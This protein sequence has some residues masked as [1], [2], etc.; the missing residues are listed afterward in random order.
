MLDCYQQLVYNL[1]MLCGT[2]NLDYFLKEINM[3]FKSDSKSFKLFQALRNG[4]SLTE[5]QITQRFGLK[6]PTATIS[7]L[8]LNHGVCVYADE[9]FDSHNRRTVKYAIGKPS[10]KLIAAGYKAM[11]LGLV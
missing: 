9:H 3:R 10:R 1:Q 5:A 7:S 4:E 2:A 11:A 8:R 6:N